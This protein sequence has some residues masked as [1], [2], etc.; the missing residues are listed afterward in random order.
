MIEIKET[1]INPEFSGV[2][3]GF[4]PGCASCRAAL[5]KLGNLEKKYNIG[6]YKI[7]LQENSKAAELMSAEK[8]PVICLFEKGKPVFSGCGIGSIKELEEVLEGVKK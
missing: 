3:E 6:F 2:V 4:T 7:N 8:L 1:D 5:F